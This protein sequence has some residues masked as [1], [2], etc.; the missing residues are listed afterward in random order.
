LT[1]NA[2]SKRVQKWTSRLTNQC[3][4][5]YENEAGTNEGQHLMDF[6]SLIFIPQAGKGEFA[7]IAEAFRHAP[8]IH[9]PSSIIAIQHSYVEWTNVAASHLALEAQSATGFFMPLALVPLEP[10]LNQNAC[11]TGFRRQPLFR[12]SWHGHP[13]GPCV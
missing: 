10:F 7:E 4:F 2:G 11:G 12:L 1:V 9:K 5:R 8:P 3:G 13:C 6:D